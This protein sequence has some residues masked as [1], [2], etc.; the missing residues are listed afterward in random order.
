MRSHHR[1]IRSDASRQREHWRILGKCHCEFVV[2]LK[3]I[4]PW[5]MVF[6]FSRLNDF[7]TTWR[8][9][10]AREKEQAVLE[11]L[12]VMT[13]GLKTNRIRLKGLWRVEDYC[14]H[15]FVQT[16]TIKIFCCRHTKS[17]I[18]PSLGCIKCSSFQQ[19]TVLHAP[20]KAQGLWRKFPKWTVDLQYNTHG[21]AHY[22]CLWCCATV[23]LGVFL[24]FLS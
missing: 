10:F 2:C 24:E 15:F 12:L 6:A 3:A 9:W 11:G 4:Q 13:Y 23:L 7:V 17:K 8:I 14:L 1:G 20:I 16:L 19:Y 21:L 18:Q 5:T 22:A